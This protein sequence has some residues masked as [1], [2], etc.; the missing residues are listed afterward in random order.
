[1]K[2]KVYIIILNWNGWPD[3]VECLES[4]LKS[5]YPNFHVVICDNGSTDGSCDK[6][7]DWAEGKCELILCSEN[8]QV[9]CLISPP[10]AKPLGIFECSRDEALLGG[11]PESA[12]CR[13]TMIRNGAN[14][15]FAGGNNVGIRYALT[16]N[17]FEYAWLLNNDTVVHQDA[18]ARMVERM[19]DC[20]KAGICGSKLLFYDSPDTVQALGGATFNRYLSIPQH[21]GVGLKSGCP[22]D[23]L[24][25]E[26]EMDY[27]VGASMLVS[28]TFLRQI[29][30]LEE[31]YFLFYEEIDWAVRSKGRFSLVFAPDSV[32]YHKEGRSIGT[33]SLPG[34]DSI[35]SDYF[36]TRNR[37]VFT[38]KHFPWLLPLTYL[39]VFIVL[40]NRVRRR[41]WK[42]VAMVAAILFGNNT[43]ALSIVAGEDK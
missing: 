15:G 32:V 16:K 4:V 6:I 18:L 35:K 41:Q 36:R 10:V 38:K 33:N 31:E 25:V 13:V 14:L 22:V 5:S 40:L 39:V 27:V 26:A 23:R 8:P 12:Q 2:V 29:G 3:T 19:T 43:V 20:T 28:G 11:N 21:I 34:A 24:L 7:L 1:M 17:D 30:L 37:I 42:R 9:N